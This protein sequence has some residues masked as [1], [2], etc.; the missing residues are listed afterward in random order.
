MSYFLAPFSNNVL[1]NILSASFVA[2][3]IYASVIY[4]R[5]R[6]AARNG[7]YAAAS[8]GLQDSE[9]RGAGY[10]GAVAYESGPPPS[11]VHSNPFAT[12]YNRSTNDLSAQPSMELGRTRSPAQHDNAAHAPELVAGSANRYYNPPAFAPGVAELPTYNGPSATRYGWRTTYWRCAVEEKGAGQQ[13]SVM[14]TILVDPYSWQGVTLSLAH[15]TYF[16]P[17]HNGLLLSDA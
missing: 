1:T 2:L 8:T 14:I 11:S 16:S 12:P 5:A 3:L 4:H 15:W 7:N 13:H 9:Y 17:V 10:G 6:K